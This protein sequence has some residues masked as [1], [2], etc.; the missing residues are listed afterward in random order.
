MGGPVASELIC[1][2]TG[3]IVIGSTCILNYGAS[4]IAEESIILGDRCMFGSYVT[5]HDRFADRR[6]PV[7][8]EDDVWVA[9]GAVI[10]PGVRI[11]ARSVVSARSRVERD[12]PPDSLAIGRPARILPLH[13][14]KRSVAESIQ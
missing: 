4:L 9:H 6:G 14:I 7:V 12:I 1:R 8:I 2:G 13:L 3:S 5:V 11:G 10:E